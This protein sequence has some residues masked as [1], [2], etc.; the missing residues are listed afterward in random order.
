MKLILRILVFLVI[1]QCYAQHTISGTFTP[2]ADYTWLLAYKLGED[3]QSYIGDAQITEGRFSLNLPES[4]PSGTYRLV[5]AV[6][7]D[8]YYFDVIYNGK[9][10]I[11]LDFN[12]ESGITF[13]G[14]RENIIFNNYLRDIYLIEQEIISFYQ[15]GSTD[16]V[17][18]KV[19]CKQLSNT[20]EEYE[21][22]SEKYMANIFIRSNAPYI[23]SRFEPLEEYVA[24]RKAAYFE[25]IDLKNPQLQAS[26]FLT[27]KLINFVFT[28]IPPRPM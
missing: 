28:A 27:D 10:N 22:A 25:P 26:G 1:L 9:E 7:Q 12:A 16:E 3:A 18:F 24:N 21:A 8:E 23:P 15:S 17:R 14:S 4:S 11:S 20:Q 19:L 6:P 13:N 2:A 5:Y